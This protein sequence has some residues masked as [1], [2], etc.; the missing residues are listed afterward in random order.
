M[1]NQETAKK[2]Y[3]EWMIALFAAGYPLV[4][5]ALL[6]GVTALTEAQKYGV[7]GGLPV[8]YAIY[9]AVKWKIE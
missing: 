2:Y 4:I 8:A 7:A 1:K 3:T 9:L 5:I 6:N